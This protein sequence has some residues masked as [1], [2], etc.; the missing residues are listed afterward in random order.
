MKNIFSKTTAEKRTQNGVKTDSKRT[1]Y[2][3]RIL[4]FAFLT[5]GVG[6]AWADIT[7]SGGYI[8]F[9]NSLGIN[10]NTLQICARQSSWTGVSSFSNIDN[11]KLYYVA[12]P[13][14]SGWGGILGWV[15]I[16]A[17]P[18]KNNSNFDNW[19]S[20]TWC[21]DWNTYG[22]NSGSTYLIVPSSTSKSLSVTTTYYSG[23]YS[24]FN[25]TQTINTVVKTG[26]G[27]YTA[28]NS[29][30]TISI[31]SYK[32]T[33][34]GAVTK[35]TTSISTS[36]KTQTVSAAR[37]ATTTYI[38]GDVASGYQFDGWYTAATGGTQLSA[39]KTYTYYPTAATTVYAR[40]S[41]KMS[42]VT[43]TASPSEKGSFTIGGA[44]A[45]STTA[46]VTTTRSVTAVPIS[47]YHFVS[48][49][50]SGGASISSTTT[51]PTTVTGDGTGDAATLTATFEADAVNSLTVSKGTGISTV[52]GST[53]P[54]TLGSKYAISATVATGYTFSGWTAT[55]AANGT[56]DNASSA[57]TNV[58]VKNGS[59]VVTASGT[60]R[61]S[62]LR[63]SN[64]YDV[65]NPSY[66]APTK[67]ASSIGISTTATL[68][69]TT[70]STGYT[71]AG[72][73]LS[74]N[75]VVTSGN[76]ATDLSITVHTTGNGVAATAQANY[77]EDLSTPYVLNGGSAFGTPTWGQSLAFTKKSGESTGT[78]AYAEIPISAAVGD[79]ANTNYNFKVVKK[80]APDVWYGLSG[81]GDWRYSSSS[82]EQTMV[83]D[84]QNIQL[85]A[86][87]VGTYTVKL[88]YTNSSS[89]KI[90]ITWPV[91]LS[92][93]RSNPT[94]GTNI[95]DHAWNSMPTST[96]YR[97]NLDLEANTTYEFKINDKG[98]YY[99]H[100][101]EITTS[102]SN[103]E[104]STGTG[105]TKLKTKSAGRFI[106]TW[107]GSGHHL[108]VVYPKSADMTASPASVYTGGTTTLTGY[109][110]ELGSGSH[111]ITYEFY[112]GTELI[113]GNLIATKVKTESATYQQETQDVTVNFDGNTTSQIYT[114]Q[115]K[116][117]GSI[118]ATN[119]VTVYRKW[120]IYVHD[121]ASWNAMKLYMYS[122]D[123]LTHNEEWPGPDCSN[124]NGSTTW[125]TVPLDA[126][127]DRFILNNNAGKKQTFAGEGA[128]RT[129]ITTYIPGT[130]WYTDFNSTAGGI[131]YYGLTNITLSTP[132]VT[133]AATVTNATQLNLTGTVT[134]CG[135][136][137]SFASDMKEVYFNVNNVKD[138]ASITASTTDGTF[139]KSL[140]NPTP[141]NTNNTLQAA[142]TNIYDTGTS[143]AIRFSRVTLDKQSGRPNSYR[144]Y[145]RRILRKHRW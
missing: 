144:I 45:T 134:N 108:T 95:G 109:A 17:N 16:S 11:T 22:F 132:T 90:T 27:S 88:D 28:A 39:S 72:W 84:N 93:Y 65:G 141:D 107:D 142:A 136:D 97:W 87:V 66:A 44:A 103:R 118:L 53:S 135:G 91:A 127:Y 128:L 106:F 1:N 104:F 75:L 124:Y 25:S 117:G 85:R 73:T 35:Q 19:S 42:T 121:V 55:P 123:G 5:L 115:I 18:A 63:T 32:M 43:L 125:Y 36:A 64:H 50:I 40:F 24:A 67:S 140:N 13:Q 47:G 122:E 89:P 60:E 114:I 143:S 129:D 133:I 20:Y 82:G 112:K 57:S 80:G 119:T 12:D 31:T 74:N 59:V 98:S 78:I 76:A 61:M 71:F 21:S 6:Q 38:V 110:S 14:G 92:I 3:F 37:T 113:A 58:T 41:E 23:G 48:W 51:N 15:V 77:E 96:S 100:D 29:K 131:S 130:Y 126:K 139:T 54:V 145:L 62:T 10:D 86:N 116:E 8:Y 46:G 30:A 105:D 99:G 9:D 69:A 33:G 138:A 34:N 111:T 83:V 68:T 49:S 52:S 101:T 120:D 70:P 7:Y 2:G 56:F 137:G 81:E 94:D 4:I 102:I 79:G 26:S